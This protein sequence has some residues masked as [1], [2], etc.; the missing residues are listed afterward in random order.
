MFVFGTR[1]HLALEADAAYRW[2]PRSD[3]TLWVR[4]HRVLRLKP[5]VKGGVA[6]LDTPPETSPTPDGEGEVS[7]LGEGR[8]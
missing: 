8:H 5:H 2:F 1:G 7:K 3:A 6:P 4:P